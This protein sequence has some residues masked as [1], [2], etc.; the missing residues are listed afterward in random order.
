MAGVIAA[1]ASWAVMGEGWGKV[2]STGFFFCEPLVVCFTGMAFI[3]DMHAG[4]SASLEN[5]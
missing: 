1:A 5:H 2:L 3:L 4:G